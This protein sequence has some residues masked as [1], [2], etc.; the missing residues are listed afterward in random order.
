MRHGK[1]TRDFDAV[2]AAPF[3][4]VGFVLDGDAITDISFLDKNTPL[5]PPRSASARK[6]ARVLQSYFGN[7]GMTFRLPLK[8]GGTAF[9]QR[10]WRALRRIP[11]GKTLSYG[12]LAR[13]LD[14]SARA[15]GNACRANPV[16][17]IIPCHRVVASNGVG[18]F[19]GKRSGSP[20][21]L[22]HW[23]LAHERGK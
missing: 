4:R 10:V 3:G 20:L 7:P 2:I 17:I 13:K 23:L 12:R 11:A 14:T 21:G 16:P 22:K 18:G 8:L 9:Q 15:V 6:V 1:R 19:M 5:S